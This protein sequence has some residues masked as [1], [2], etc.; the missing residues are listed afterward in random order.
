MAGAL[1]TS[2]RCDEEARRHGEEIAGALVWR[3]DLAGF[4]GQGAG[5]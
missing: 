3:W 5:K 2:Q 1:G 4:L